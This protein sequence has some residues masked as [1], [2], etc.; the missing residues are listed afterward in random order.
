VHNFVDQDCEAL[1]VSSAVKSVAKGPND[2]RAAGDHQLGVQSGENGRYASGTSGG[3]LQIVFRCEIP[4]MRNQ[5]WDP[6]PDV[7]SHAAE[8]GLGEA[9]AKVHD[10]LEP[11]SLQGTGSEVA[12]LAF[13]AVDDDLAVAWQFAEATAELA[14][15]D[16]DRVS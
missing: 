9:S 2:N 8:L 7:L 4:Y 11:A 6:S 3:G 16:M 13:L 15:R 5:T 12:A 10:I 14:E 1:A